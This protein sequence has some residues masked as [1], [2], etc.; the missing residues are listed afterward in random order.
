MNTLIGFITFLLYLTG[1]AISF[2]FIALFLA[3]LAVVAVKAFRLLIALF[4]QSIAEP[5]AAIVRKV[6]NLNIQAAKKQQRKKIKGFVPNQPLG[7]PAPKKKNRK[8][9]V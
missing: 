1:G 9:K 7:S 5:E 4:N 3:V 2:M 6:Q 8:N